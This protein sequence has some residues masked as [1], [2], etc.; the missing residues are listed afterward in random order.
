MSAARC[1]ANFT[2]F[3]RSLRG[4]SCT[5]P[6]MDTET[7]SDRLRIATKARTAK[8]VA[9][10]IGM[11]PETVRRYFNGHAP[12]A[13]F[14]AKVCKVYEVN[15]TWMLTGMGYPTMQGA[16]KDALNLS[17]HTE[18]LDTLASK[19]THMEQRSESLE[20][21]LTALRGKGTRAEARSFG[22]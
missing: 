20:R 14:L 12:S 5:M 10:E 22:R 1:A 8:Q 11:N 21:E 15:G 16:K 18:L 4:M 2:D 17:G 3:P 19:L 9:D 13:E 6:R 7:I